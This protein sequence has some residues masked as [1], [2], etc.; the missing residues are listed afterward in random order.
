MKE[1][2]ISELDDFLLNNTN[3]SQ[4]EREEVIK[5]AISLDIALELDIM[6]RCGTMGFCEN[7]KQGFSD[8]Y[9]TSN[10]EDFC[11][12]QCEKEYKRR[13]DIGV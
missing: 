5:F 2:G 1:L 11:S 12:T 6:E 8:K 3:I 13:K 4:D 10:N 9:R 7:C